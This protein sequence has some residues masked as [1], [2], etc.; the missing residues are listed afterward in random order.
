[1]NGYVKISIYLPFLAFLK[2][3]VIMSIRPYSILGIRN[4]YERKINTLSMS[5]LLQTV[6]WVLQHHFRTFSFTKGCVSETNYI[7]GIKILTKW[8]SKMFTSNGEPMVSPWRT[9]K[10]N[11]NSKTQIKRE[12]KATYNPNATTVAGTFSKNIFK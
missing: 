3:I 6:K 2:V 9:S 12:V 1:M 5:Y 8:Y 10:V 7:F 11:I 4:I